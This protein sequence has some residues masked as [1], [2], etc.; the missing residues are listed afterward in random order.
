[1]ECVVA[2]LIVVEIANPQHRHTARA[3]RR[4]KREWTQC[5]RERPMHV[6]TDWVNGN[7][8][9]WLICYI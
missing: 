2:V 7:I 6:Q 3:K 1:M 9:N 4:A 5:A 8:Y